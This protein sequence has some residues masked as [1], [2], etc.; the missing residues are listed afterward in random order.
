MHRHFPSIATAAALVCSAAAAPLTAPD[1][2]AA[3][4]IAKEKNIPVAVFVHG[5]SWHRASKLY[6][7]KI[8]LSPEFRNALAGPLV[9]TNIHIRQNPGKEQAKADVR[10]RKGWNGKSVSTYPAVQVIA[11][12]GHLLKTYAG[13]GLR[14]LATP[15]SLAKHLNHVLGNAAKRRALLEKITRARKENNRAAELEN[16]VALVELPLNNEAN[17]TGQFKKIDPADTTGWQARL[18]FKNWEFVRR[19]SGLARGK[20]YGQAIAETDRLLASSGHTPEQRAL[21]LGAKGMALAAEGKLTEA[22][23]VFKRA[24]QADPRG[25][26]GKAVL[27]YGTRVAG[28]PSREVLPADSSLGGKAIGGNISRDHASY[29]Q[30]SSE[31]GGAA[32]HTSLFKGAY[33]R[34]GFAFHTQNE[35]GAHIVV[36]LHGSCQVK[37]LRVTNRN[38]LHNR[39]AGLTVW[40]SGDRENW[41]RL[42]TAEKPAAAWDVLLEHPVTARYLKVGLDPGTSNF[43]HL[44][45]VDVYGV[46]P[47]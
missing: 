29:T 4:A 18:S 32:G 43:L 24:H 38:N 34:R 41:T 10:S 23:N 39:A 11:A 12:D 13:R 5:S 35:K 9:L 22:W 46:R 42:W 45:A 47:D 2:A 28:V 17:I 37:A 33:A 44:R 25:A 36:D 15:E 8:W 40:A 16:L 27:R 3:A 1:F 6:G 31:G 7:E 20:K 19:I 26:N 30:S 14:P 21:I